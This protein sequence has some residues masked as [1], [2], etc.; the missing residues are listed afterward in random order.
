MV[1]TL[2]YLRNKLSIAS[3]LNHH[4]HHNRPVAI[5][6]LI[7]ISICV[8]SCAGAREPPMVQVPDQ[9]M[10]M[11]VHLK[12][13][14]TQTIAAYLGIP[15]AQPPTGPRRFQPPVIDNL[16]RW[17]GIRNATTLPAE[18]LQNPL[19]PMRKHEEAFA[20]LISSSYGQTTG[21][22]AGANE[23]AA[24][25]T[26]QYDEDCLFLNIYLPDGT[27]WYSILRVTRVY[28]NIISLL[29]CLTTCVCT[30]LVA[31]ALDPWG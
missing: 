28:E 30:C 9:G 19:Q 6:L 31:A 1:S 20:S 7:T 10:L 2:Q 8:Q 23:S 4:Q 15:Y 11:G 29:L 17:E 12:M 27:S 13:F 18:C 24:A 21:G 25:V 26:R 16:P 5:T 3:F 22:A 14:R